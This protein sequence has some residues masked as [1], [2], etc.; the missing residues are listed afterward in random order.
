[1]DDYIWLNL[2][3]YISLPLATKYYSYTDE[4]YNNRY[5]SVFNTEFGNI[6]EKYHK[7]I[8]F[9]VDYNIF[10]WKFKKEPSSNIHAFSGKLL[11][12]F[13]LNTCKIIPIDSYEKLND[14]YPK[15]LCKFAFINTDYTHR[16][17]K[18]IN[19]IKFKGY[20]ID[21]YTFMDELR[22]YEL[23]KYEYI[24]L[25]NYKNPGSVIIYDEDFN[26]KMITYEENKTEYKKYTNLILNNKESIEKQF[27]KEENEIREMLI[28][29]ISDNETVSNLVWFEYPHE[30]KKHYTDIK[31]V[32]LLETNSYFIVFNFN[33]FE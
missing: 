33:K 19:R 29:C 28:K 10:I 15:E 23:R 22:K 24:S 18:A 12:T 25:N 7:L 17:I 9:H 13:N 2:D 32:F 11:E 5:N 30:E 4:P 21:E 8:S 1:M 27:R 16:W 20:Y 3:K 31:N 14:Y 6:P 26:Y